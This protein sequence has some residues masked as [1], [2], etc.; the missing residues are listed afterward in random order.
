VDLAGGGLTS[1]L[2]TPASTL[3]YQPFW[4]EIAMSE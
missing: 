3:P 1:R 4:K 2:F